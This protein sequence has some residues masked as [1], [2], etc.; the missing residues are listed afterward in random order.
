MSQA[1]QSFAIQQGQDVD[2]SI[3]CSDDDGTFLDFTGMSGRFAAARDEDSTPVLD[4]DASPFTA[5]VTLSSS[6][7]LDGV[8]TVAL[9]D[10]DLDSLEGDYY[11]ELKLTDSNGY[12][13]V[14]ARGIIS[15]E[16]ALT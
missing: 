5:S 8:V 4:S 14:A 16:K 1:Y 13:T 7:P 3:V 2:L 12:E 11:Y 9:R 15:V 10:T 6:S